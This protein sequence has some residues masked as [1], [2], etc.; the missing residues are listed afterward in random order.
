[1]CGDLVT[2]G[3]VAETQEA[4][5]LA[6]VEPRREVEIFIHPQDRRR[7]HSNRGNQHLLDLQPDP[8]PRPRHTGHGA[9]HGE[10]S[11]VMYCCKRI[12]F[13]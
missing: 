13:F 2:F 3:M 5:I 9:K 12:V 11:V 8:R 6:E 1:M 4:Q 7:L 10:Y